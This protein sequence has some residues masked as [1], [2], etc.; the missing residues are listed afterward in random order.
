MVYSDMPWKRSSGSSAYLVV[1]A[2]TGAGREWPGAD[3]RF[4][5]DHAAAV[6]TL[7]R[8]RLRLRVNQRWLDWLDR[9]ALI[10]ISMIFWNIPVGYQRPGRQQIDRSL[11][12]AP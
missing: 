3:R 2:H 6:R 5:G 9:G 11:G 1:V 8:D 10:T 7:L 12:E 4:C